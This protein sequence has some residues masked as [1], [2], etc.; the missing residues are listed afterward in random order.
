MVTIIKQSGKPIDEGEAEKFMEEWKDGFDKLFESE[1]DMETVS[2][3]AEAYEE[4][5]RKKYDL[6]KV[7]Q[8]PKSMKAWK[9]LLEEHNSSI[10]VDIH[11]KTGKLLFIILDQG[12]K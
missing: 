4:K 8:V 10:M 3:K 7:I 1:T 11:A 5:L 6:E 12:I 2:K 9:D